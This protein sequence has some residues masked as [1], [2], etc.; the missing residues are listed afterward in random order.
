MLSF[1]AVL[2]TLETVSSQWVVYVC[3][4]QYTQWYNMLTIVKLKLELA[5]FWYGQNIS[6]V[7]YR[8]INESWHYKEKV[9]QQNLFSSILYIHTSVFEL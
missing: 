7:I 5:T 9:W 6:N 8:F 1:W 3:T 4:T 2:A